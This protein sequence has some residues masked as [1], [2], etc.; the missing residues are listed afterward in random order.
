M[1]NMTMTCFKF[2]SA[3]KVHESELDFGDRCNSSGGISTD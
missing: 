2:K 1:I 3:E